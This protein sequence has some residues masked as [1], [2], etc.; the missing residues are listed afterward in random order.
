MSDELG[1]LGAP[2]NG[3]IYVRDKA[4]A[5]EGRTP[6]VVKQAVH[7]QWVDT[8][9]NVP[10]SWAM[11]PGSKPR[12]PVTPMPPPLYPNDGDAEPETDPESEAFNDA[13]PEPQAVAEGEAP[14]RRPGRPRTRG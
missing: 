9:L 14:K 1:E 12:D 2:P 6:T 8:T 4:A 5:R 11:P 7:P 13:A 10:P 3:F